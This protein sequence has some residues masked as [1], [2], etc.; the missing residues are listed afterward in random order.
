MNLQLLKSP[1]QNARQF[2]RRPVAMCKQ[3]GIESSPVCTIAK[4]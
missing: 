3:V 1:P 4:R 2:T